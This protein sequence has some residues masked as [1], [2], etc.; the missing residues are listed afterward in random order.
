MINVDMRLYDYFTL[1]EPNAYGQPQLPKEDAEPVGKIKMAI[2]TSSQSIQEN[3]NYKDC[4]YIGLTTA[5]LDDKYIIQYG[6]ERLKVLY[7]NP[8]GRFKQAFLQKI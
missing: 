5:L 4:S 6:N 1:G 2:Y 7:V 8:K 3:I